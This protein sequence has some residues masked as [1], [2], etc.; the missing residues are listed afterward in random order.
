MKLQVGSGISGLGAALALSEKHEV[1]L[2]KKITALA[3]T[4]TL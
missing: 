3:D 1:F 4:Q 2:L